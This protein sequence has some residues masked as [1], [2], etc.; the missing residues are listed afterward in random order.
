MAL[1][2]PLKHIIIEAADPGLCREVDTFFYLQF[3]LAQTCT[4]AGKDPGCCA[5]DPSACSVT[6]NGTTCYCDRTCVA[7]N[8]CC[9]DVPV[10][11]GKQI[12]IMLQ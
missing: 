4:E 12:I 11:C 3:Y 6:A 8:D 5:G 7:Y 10:M 9:S 2:P 1:N